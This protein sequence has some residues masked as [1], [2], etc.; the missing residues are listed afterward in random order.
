MQVRL[1][2]SKTGIRRDVEGDQGDVCFIVVVVFMHFAWVERECDVRAIMAE[3]TRIKQVYA[4]FAANRRRATDVRG[5]G[6][7]DEAGATEGGEG[8]GG[9]Q[10]AR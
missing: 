7:Q 6:W 2:I 8:G 1:S 9:A 5:G 3:R 10:N 4:T